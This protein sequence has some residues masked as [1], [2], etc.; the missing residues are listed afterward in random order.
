M[1]QCFMIIKVLYFNKYPWKFKYHIHRSQK[2][3]YVD[4]I[5]FSWRTTR[6]LSMS[7]K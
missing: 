5:L 7:S 3:E 6:T 4:R 2:T 1:Y